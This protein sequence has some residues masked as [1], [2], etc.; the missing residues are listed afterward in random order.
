MKG[1][2]VHYSYADTATGQTLQGSIHFQ[3]KNVPPLNKVR[4]NV[5]TKWKQKKYNSGVYESIEITHT[6]PTY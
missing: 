3:Q 2:L 4:A 5:L 6:E 1:I